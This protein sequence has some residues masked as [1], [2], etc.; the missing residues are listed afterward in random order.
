MAAAVILDPLKPIAD[1]ADSKVL[2]AKKRST[3]AGEIR[4][5]ALAWAIGRAEV[6]EIDQLNIL[7]ASLLAMRRAVLGLDLLPGEVLV[8]G[9]RCPDLPFVTKA[10]V[11]GDATVEM[12]SAASIL[13]K[14]TR[15]AEMVGFDKVYPQY[16]F[17]SHK[18]YPTREHLRRLRAFGPCPIH[19]RSFRPVYEW[20][21]ENQ[22]ELTLTTVQATLHAESR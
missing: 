16:K 9:N 19:R 13:A 14:V 3:L 22:R 5:K 15:D 11:R 4:V 8:D 18:G 1:L 2:S 21:E 20:V 17:A 7:Q 6:D 10:I 12:I